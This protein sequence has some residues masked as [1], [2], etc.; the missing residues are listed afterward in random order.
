MLT[1]PEAE[2]DSP[3]APLYEVHITN[4][5]A[6]SDAWALD[7]Y[8]L[9]GLPADNATKLAFASLIA[10]PTT[11]KGIKAALQVTKELTNANLQPYQTGDP[12]TPAWHDVRLGLL[13]NCRSWQTRIQSL[14]RNH[15]LILAANDV[16]QDPFPN[17]R[18]RQ[19]EDETEKEKQKE[20]FYIFAEQEDDGPMVFYK[21]F[22]K[23]GPTPTI[24]EWALQIW[25]Q[26]L[27]F[28]QVRPLTAWGIYGWRCDL[29]F[30]VMENSI[31]SLI[32]EGALPIP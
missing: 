10:P 13:R 19:T 9:P 23:R 28:N 15:H 32:A 5:T 26:A 24:P 4:V 14:G 30:Q 22:A 7:T 25:E 20:T 29:D 31:V 12:R 18:L 17:S 8:P 16:P 2:P 27:E 11:M 21:Q 3:P 6:M 1:T